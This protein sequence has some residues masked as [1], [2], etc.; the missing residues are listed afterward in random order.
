MSSEYYDAI[1]EVKVC[2]TL[3]EPDRYLAAHGDVPT[4]SHR[5]NGRVQDHRPAW[6]VSVR[7]VTFEIVLIGTQA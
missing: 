1:Y 4:H 6:K 5:D 7:D 3:N 2:T